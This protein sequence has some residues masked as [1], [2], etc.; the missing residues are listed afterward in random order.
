M[1]FNFLA[2]YWYLY[3]C[4]CQPLGYGHST[5][6][7]MWQHWHMGVNCHSVWEPYHL[8]VKIQA[9]ILVPGSTI[10]SSSMPVPGQFYP[11]Q[12]ICSKA[13]IFFAVHAVVTATLNVPYSE[14][15]NYFLIY[16][17][18]GV[19]LFSL[20]QNSLFYGTELCAVI[21]FCRWMKKHEPRCSNYAKL[22]TKFSLQR[23]CML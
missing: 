8:Y 23:S 5:P 1:L 11:S 10:Y 12:F 4:G 16:N 17:E 13:I 9:N 21:P 7:R 19:R 6:C 2:F 20:N 14:L 22:G 15:Q 3:F 18:G